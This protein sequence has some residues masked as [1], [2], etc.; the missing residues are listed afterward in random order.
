MSL[1]IVAGRHVEMM[2]VDQR[3]RPH[4]LGGGHVVLD[5]RPEHRQ[6]PLVKHAC[7]PPWH[8]AVSECQFYWLTSLA[9]T[10]RTVVGY[11]Y[12]S[13]ATEWPATDA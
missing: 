5:D 3:L 4:R 7:S 10:A 8:S 11:A 9:E 6:F 12:P 13:Q 2:P 1:R